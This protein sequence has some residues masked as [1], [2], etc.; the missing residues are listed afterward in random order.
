MWIQV[1]CGLL[2][3][4][5]A[6]PA[7]AN[8]TSSPVPGPM[9]EPE[10]RPWGEES[11]G[12][13]CRFKAPDRLEQGMPLEA[14][15]EFRSASERLS[16]G[17]TKLNRFLADAS[18]ELTLFDPRT[19]ASITVRP[20]DP[21]SGMPVQDEGK[22]VELLD[23]SD[24][25]S[26]NT[27]FPL[28]TVWSTLKAGIYQARVRYSFP[29]Q[30]QKSWWRGTP[31]EWDAIWKGTVV[32]APVTLQI[33]AAT[34]RT[35]TL[36][37]PRRVRL[38]PGLTIGYTKE[39]AEKVEVP[40]RNGFVIG[41]SIAGDA[42]QAFSVQSGPPKPDDNPIDELLGYHGGDKKRSYTITVFE[43]ADRA[44]HMWHPGPG[45]G[46]Y[47]EL[48]KKTFDLSLSEKELKES[49]GTGSRSTP[50]R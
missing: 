45:S 34:Q 40:R 49:A 28:A 4:V 43:T 2:A 47:R 17:V 18:L 7:L 21:T 37:L 33:L 6:A 36:L 9:R 29:G 46:D 8:G 41:T 27:S 30:Y 11:E 32:S 50:I 10:N 44:R 31:A 38:L 42:A 48:W 25:R 16:P 12:L 39:D 14:E 24:P 35:E 19:K 13:R 20:Y 26:L 22:Q 1:C 3:L 23:K 5:M 15:I